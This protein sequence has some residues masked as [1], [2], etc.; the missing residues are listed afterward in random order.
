MN[1]M[2]RCLPWAHEMVCGYVEQASRLSG[3][4][5]RLA[6]EGAPD[7]VSAS[8]AVYVTERGS[9]QLAGL[10]FVMWLLSEAAEGRRA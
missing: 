3:N 6:A 2:N 8:F 4:S 9:W 1:A 10:W 5:R 7:A